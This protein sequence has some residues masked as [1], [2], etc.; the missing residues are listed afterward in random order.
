MGGQ[1]RDLFARVESALGTGTSDLP[2]RA[3]LVY[4]LRSKL[5]H[6]GA[7]SANELSGAEREARELLELALKAEAL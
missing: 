4:D 3:L 6:D 1:V 2:K 5:V 7:L